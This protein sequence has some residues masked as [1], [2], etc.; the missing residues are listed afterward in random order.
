MPDN[1]EVKQCKDC[2]RD[3]EITESEKQRFIQKGYEIPKR[4]K[5]CRAKRKAEKERELNGQR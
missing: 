5:E 3:W 2:G 4:C 1:V